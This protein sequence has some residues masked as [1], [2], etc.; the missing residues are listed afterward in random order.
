[1]KFKMKQSRRLY[2]GALILLAVVTVVTFSL[3]V[4]LQCCHDEHQH[5]HHGD[6]DHGQ[7]H[8]HHFT[9]GVRPI[10]IRVCNDAV[11]R[12]SAM[13]LL[14]GTIVGSDTFGVEERSRPFPSTAS[15]APLD[16]GDDYLL[17]SVFIC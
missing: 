10:D 13:T 9:M 8:H 17:N 7:A 3:E 6:G 4:G 15:P 16:S 5:E 2:R 1:M 11:G 14:P 12:I